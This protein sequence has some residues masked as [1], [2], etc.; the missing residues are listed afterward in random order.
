VQA[1]S[2]PQEAARI[3]AIDSLARLGPLAAPAK[4]QIA[5]AA[6]DSSE[7]V[8]RISARW[9]ATLPMGSH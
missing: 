5:A 6:S 9:L 7:Y 3:A 8:K 1:L 4:Q 2:D